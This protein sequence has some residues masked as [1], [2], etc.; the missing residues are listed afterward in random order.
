MAPRWSNDGQWF[1]YLRQ[2]NY[3]FEIWVSRFANGRITD[4]TRIYDE[5]GVDAQSGVS[6]WV[7]PAAATPD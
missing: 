3:E 7:E 2:E 5:D 4:Q 1:A 6:W